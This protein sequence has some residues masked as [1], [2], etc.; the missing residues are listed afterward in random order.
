MFNELHY[1]LY[2]SHNGDVLQSGYV[3][4]QFVLL[5]NELQRALDSRS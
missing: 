2:D 4:S 5:G 3:R 1:L